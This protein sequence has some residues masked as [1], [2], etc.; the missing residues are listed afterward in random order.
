MVSTDSTRP[1]L[2]SP[3]EVKPKDLEKQR[4]EETAAKGQTPEPK[5][6]AAHGSSLD[7]GKEVLHT[8]AADTL[9]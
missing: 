3:T 2:L 6:W 8:H 5:G 4:Q 9:D 1:E 7:R